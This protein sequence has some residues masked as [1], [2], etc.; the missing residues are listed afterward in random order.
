MNTQPEHEAVFAEGITYFVFSFD[1]GRPLDVQKTADKILRSGIAETVVSPRNGEVRVAHRYR[2]LVRLMRH[3]SALT[4]LAQALQ[5]RTL[6]RWA[7]RHPIWAAR[8]IGRPFFPRLGLSREGGSRRFDEVIDS[9][10]SN[11]AFIQEAVAREQ[12]INAMQHEAEKRLLRPDY[13]QSEPYLRLRLRSAGLWL[14]RIDGG[15]MRAPGDFGQGVEADVL[16]LIHRSGVMQ[17]TVA[18]RA[19]SG[20]KAD[21][22]RDLAFASSENVSAARVS[23][24]VLR[25]VY[26]RR[27]KAMLEEVAGDWDEEMEAGARW[28]RIPF[29]RPSS[30]SSLFS[31]YADGIA[32]VIDSD[33]S[34]DWF[35]FPVTFID[36]VDCCES[37]ERFKQVHGVE[38][39]NAILR[40]VD[41]SD[42]RPEFLEGLMPP[43]SSLTRATSLYFNMSSSFEVRWPGSP[44]ADF[45]GHLQRL[46]VFE[47]ALLQYWQIRLLDRRVGITS[48]KLK[49]VRSLQVEAIFGLRE[50]RESSISYGTAREIVDQLSSEWRN[51]RLYGHVLESVDQLQQLVGAAESARSAKRANSLAAI[52]L[53]AAIFLGL[54]AV[55]DTLDIAEKVEVDGFLALPLKPFRYL[56]SRGDEG[57]WIGYLLFLS[58]VTFSLLLLVIGRLVPRLRRRQKEAGIV[59]PLGTVTVEVRDGRSTGDS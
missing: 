52:A 39:K 54:P 5:E 30:V 24:P 49:E 19:P 37:G 12:L 11:I 4:G 3:T 28:R 16:L 8:I 36:K 59:W 2:D 27:T 7:M 10:N 56:A 42:I 1:A 47:S 23:E 45:Y 18:L 26:G 50:Y 40:S 51:D 38:L 57:T 20:V 6:R 35:C 48:G 25:A 34:G 53:V 43:D 14:T 15:G 41:V 58:G 31:L 55:G 44:S 33:W 17:L 9:L 22:Y 29:E 13:L 21:D 46:I 32:N